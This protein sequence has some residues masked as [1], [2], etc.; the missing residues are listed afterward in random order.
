[1]YAIDEIAAVKAVTA[2]RLPLAGLS[3]SATRPLD[4]RLAPMA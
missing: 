3:L 4:Y 2:T 1:M